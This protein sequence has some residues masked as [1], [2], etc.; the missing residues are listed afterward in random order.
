MTTH[1]PR[2]QLIMLH[3]HKIFQHIPCPIQEQVARL[4]ADDHGGS[5]AQRAIGCD[6]RLDAQGGVSIHHEDPAK[7]MRFAGLFLQQGAV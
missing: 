1:T 7:P 3:I 6:G 5:V 4:T 2:S